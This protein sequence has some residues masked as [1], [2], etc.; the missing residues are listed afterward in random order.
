MFQGA[1]TIDRDHPPIGH[2]Q[3]GGNSERHA[4]A[5][6]AESAGIHICRGPQPVAGQ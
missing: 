6:T 3:R 1:V 2:R 5:E 4:N